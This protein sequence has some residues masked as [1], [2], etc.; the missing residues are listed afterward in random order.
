MKYT[1]YS[2]SADVVIVRGNVDN[3]VSKITELA[4]SQRL[5]DTEQALLQLKKQ[6]TDTKALKFGYRKQT[7]SRNYCSKSL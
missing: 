6:K 7:A 1:H 4:K 2:P 3:T 5:K